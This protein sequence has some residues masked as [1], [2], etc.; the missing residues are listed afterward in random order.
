MHLEAYY[1]SC[2]TASI[3]LDVVFEATAKVAKACRRILSIEL[4]VGAS[5]EASPRSVS[6]NMGRS[7]VS[8]LV[9]TVSTALAI[10]EPGIALG[11]QPLK[12]S[13]KAS[14]IE[15]DKSKQSKI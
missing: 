5:Q 1:S 7:E 15:L 11:L 12:P 6:A 3:K 8:Y 2:L 14:V 13:Q 4:A 9:V 10:I